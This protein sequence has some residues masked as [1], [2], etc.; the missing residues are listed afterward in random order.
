[1]PPDSRFD[2]FKGHW[3]DA[4]FLDE[5]LAGDPAW[6]NPG[7]VRS[8]DIDW[9]AFLSDVPLPRDLRAGIALKLERIDPP[10]MVVLPSVL[11][12]VF[13]AVRRSQGAPGYGEVAA[14][15]TRLRSAAE[16]L[17]AVAQGG[18]PRSR[19]SPEP[20][21]WRYDADD[22]YGKHIELGLRVQDGRSQFLHPILQDHLTMAM[23]PEA[24]SIVP[25][26]DPEEE[27]KLR[28]ARQSLAYFFK[29]LHVLI[30]TIARAEAMTRELA[31]DGRKQGRGAPEDE[32]RNWALVRLMW[33]WRDV[34]G[35]E[36][37]I[38]LR[39]IGGGRELDP[40]EPQ[41]CM[42]FVVAVLA[43][44]APVRPWYLSALEEQLRSLK[45]AIPNAS[46][47]R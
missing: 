26:E 14:Q 44:F 35:K 1:M 12:S 47:L 39:K 31:K 6:E 5:E 42:D 38:Y 7:D 21:W 2:R 20:A 25:P 13:E 43:T 37:A 18:R 33:V 8:R 9:E 23:L 17:A 11:E 16:Q 15:L 24:Y 30:P 32:A 28:V 3:F 45:P 4:S 22:V 10:L 40:P 36:V 46:L 29:H 34:L 41:G 27:E 19:P